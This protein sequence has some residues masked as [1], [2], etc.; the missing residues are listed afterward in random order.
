MNFRLRQSLA[1]ADEPPPS[2][3]VSL[4]MLPSGSR[5]APTVSSR[6]DVTITG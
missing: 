1:E 2:V 3:F 6:S 4:T 5:P